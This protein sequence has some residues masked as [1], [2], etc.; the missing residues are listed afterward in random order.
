MRGVPH[1][2][3]VL[4]AALVFTGCGRLGYEAQPGG[5]DRPTVDARVGDADGGDAGSSSFMVEESGEKVS[6]DVPG[7][8]QYF[9]TDIPPRDLMTMPL[10][11]TSDNRIWPPE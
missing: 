6:S 5:S 10:R 3:V 9:A 8:N 1:P 7:L 11:L 2:L 4:S